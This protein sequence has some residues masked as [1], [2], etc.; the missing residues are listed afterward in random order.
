M[1]SNMQKL[2]DRFVEEFGSCFCK[3]VQKRIF[4]RSYNLWD[5]EDY[6]EFEK[7]GAHVDKCPS[8][9]GKVAKWCVEI[10]L[11]EKLKKV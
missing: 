2:Y 5:P 10:I 4:R 9:S 6:K 1:C 11:E 7:A 3:D 8:I